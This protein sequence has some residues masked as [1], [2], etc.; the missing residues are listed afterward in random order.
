MK[1]G[2]SIICQRNP[3]GECRKTPLC[4]V[5]DWSGAGFHTKQPLNVGQPAVSQVVSSPN[6]QGCPRGNEWQTGKQVQHSAV[7]GLGR[8]PG[9][10]TQASRPSKPRG[11][12]APEEL[13]FPPDARLMWAIDLHAT[14]WHTSSAQQG[15]A[16]SVLVAIETQCAK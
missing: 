3:N 10:N 6:N 11:S 13:S 12:E 16:V 4:A 9:G 8:C 1:G 15:S 14:W 5:E 7:V 2:N